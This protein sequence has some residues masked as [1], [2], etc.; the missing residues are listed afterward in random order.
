[1]SSFI[2]DNPQLNDCEL[3]QTEWRLLRDTE[4][5]LQPFKEQTKR[6]EGDN[7]TLDQLQESMDFLV[8]HFEKQFHKHRSNRPFVECM[9]TVWGMSASALIEGS[10]AS[11]SIGLV[12]MSRP[13]P[14]GEQCFST[15]SMSGHLLTPLSTERA[16][17]RAGCSRDAPSTVLVLQHLAVVGDTHL[18][19][20]RGWSLDGSCG[21]GWIGWCRPDDICSSENRA[22]PTD[23]QRRLP[24][25]NNDTERV[26]LVME[27]PGNRVGTVR[28]PSC[29]SIVELFS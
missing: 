23:G 16:R 10:R 6:C 1:M 22:V 14:R 25:G 24:G 8:D 27:S 4:Q 9:T 5:S 3:S 19:R 13:K 26:R 17:G 12:L 28:H 11:W 15:P 18:G 21:R 20:R 7:V 29:L 2:H